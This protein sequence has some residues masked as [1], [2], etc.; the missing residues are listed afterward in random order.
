MPAGA[1]PSE[2]QRNGCAA[3]ILPVRKSAINRLHPEVGAPD[4]DGPAIVHEIAACH[5]IGQIAFGWVE[6]MQ[7]RIV[8]ADVYIHVAQKMRRVVLV[9]FIGLVKQQ[10]D[11]FF[12]AALRGR[13]HDGVVKEAQPPIKQCLDPLWRGRDPHVVGGD[14]RQVI[15][16]PRQKV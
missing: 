11:R 12:R 1:G 3:R 15:V 10:P 8:V 14:R 6:V 9:C 5:I 16:E 13:A 2:A 4:A 7:N